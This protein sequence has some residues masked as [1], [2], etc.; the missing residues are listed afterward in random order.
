[1]LKRRCWLGFL[2]HGR[3][4]HRDRPTISRR[5]VKTAEPKIAG[6]ILP[7]S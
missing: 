3:H 5:F 4:S 2:T 7:L 1:M 6:I